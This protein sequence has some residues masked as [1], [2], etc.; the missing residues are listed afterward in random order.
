VCG[1]STE[2]LRDDIEQS[3]PAIADIHVASHLAFDLQF[4]AAMA[5]RIERVMSCLTSRSRPPP[6]TIADRN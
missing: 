2:Q 6:K 1:I 3:V 4:N 5:M